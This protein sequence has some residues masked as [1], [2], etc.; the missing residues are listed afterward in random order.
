MISFSNFFGYCE[1]LYYYGYSPLLL[2][3]NSSVL[4]YWFDEILVE[5]VAYPLN[6]DFDEIYSTIDLLLT[7]FEDKVKLVY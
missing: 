2:V 4:M 5:A 7:L 1:N 3:E 6:S